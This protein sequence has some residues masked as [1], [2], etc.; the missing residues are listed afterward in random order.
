MSGEPKWAYH[1]A[2]HCLAVLRAQWTIRQAYVGDDKDACCTRYHVP[3]Y[4]GTDSAQDREWLDNKISIAYA[5]M[6][7]ESIA[8][9]HEDI[10]EE[11][12]HES[13]EDRECIEKLATWR[14]PDSEA[15]RTRYKEEMKAKTLGM[16]SGD[17]GALC[18]L[19]KAFLDCEEPLCV[20]SHERVLSIVQRE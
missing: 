15:K 20:F 19:A 3:S 13:R 4:G 17:R 2:G 10:P 6:I 7:A 14:H 9:G 8:G 16:L 12:W 1:E 18:K 11:V 5:G